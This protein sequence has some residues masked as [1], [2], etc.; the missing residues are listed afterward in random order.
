MYEIQGKYQT[1]KVFTDNIDAETTSQIMSL[2]N[3]EWIKDS[4]I[5]IMSDCHAGKGCVIGFTQTITNKVCPN[6]VGV[7]V[8]CSMLTIQLPKDVEIDLPRFDEVVHKVVPAGFEVHETVSKLAEKY[9]T[10]IR[11]E[12]LR[13]FHQLKDVNYLRRS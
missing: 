2:C 1:A 4:Q 11:L 12:A 7:D 10:D 6:L 13:C 3:Q 5:R 9:L 8:G